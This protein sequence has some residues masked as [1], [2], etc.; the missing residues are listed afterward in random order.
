MQRNN[1]SVMMSEIF[2]SGQGIREKL[3]QKFNSRDL[4]LQN[5]KNMIIFLP[6]PNEVLI[7]YGFEF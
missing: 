6:K 2:Y 1:L 3:N 5:S 7:S 4:L